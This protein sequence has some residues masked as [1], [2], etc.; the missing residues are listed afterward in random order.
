MAIVKQRDSN[1]ELLRIVA[2]S[3]IVIYHIFVHGISP[4]YVGS[5]SILTVWYV[6]FIF[7]VNLFIL[8]SGYYGIRLS[9][10]SFLSLM[11]IIVFYKLFHLIVDTTCL[12]IH[13]AWWEWIVK[14]LSAPAS[15]G[16]WFVDIYI[17]LMLVS[18]MLNKLLNGC[19]KGDLL[20]YSVIVLLLDMGYGF[21]LNKHFDPYGYSLIHFVCLYI[22]GYGLKSYQNVSVKDSW[23]VYILVVSCLL[24]ANL[25][26][27]DNHWIVKFS[28]SYASPFIVLGA[29]FLF[30]IFVR[31]NIAHHPFINFVAASMFPVYL[32]H[33]GGNVSKWY[34]ATVEEW[35]A[36]LSIP[37]FLLYTTGFII[38]LFVLTI[39][40]DQLRKKCWSSISCKLFNRQL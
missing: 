18:P 2:M 7:G 38:A 27:P 32:I 31:T 26:F 39:S 11:W 10:K 20:K 24:L 22:I 19:S 37:T 21:I 28:N 25:L 34:Y 33:E 29:I 40:V 12:G 23:K 13:H 14:P 6:P 15:G 36:T 16:G 1:L 4:V 17:L 9:W 35:W 8:I 3:M 30:L 5:H